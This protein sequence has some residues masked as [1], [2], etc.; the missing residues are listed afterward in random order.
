MPEV[1]DLHEILHIKIN[2]IGNYYSNE[3]VGNIIGILSDQDNKCEILHDRI[4]NIGI[5]H[6]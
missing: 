2:E 4:N 1:C 5:L 3:D 6:R